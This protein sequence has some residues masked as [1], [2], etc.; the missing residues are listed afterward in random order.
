VLGYVSTRGA[1]D[2]HHAELTRRGYVE[3]RD[4]FLCA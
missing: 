1:R 2:L 4:F 3:G